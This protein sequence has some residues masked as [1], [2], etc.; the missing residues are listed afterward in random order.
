MAEDQI[1]GEIIG[2]AAS[3]GAGAMDVI[4]YLVLFLCLLGVGAVIWWV[5]S[6]K[7]KIVVRYLTRSGAFIIEDKARSVKRDGAVF[8]SF[9]KGRVV[10][11]PPPK[12]AINVTKKG[13]LFA[14]CY[15]TEDNPEPIW[16][17]DKGLNDRTL[18]E[19]SGF[20]PLTTQQRA[21]L[22]SRCVKAN[23]RK[24]KTLWDQIRDIAIPVTMLTMVMIPFIF[25]GDI[26]KTSTDA[27]DQAQAVQTQNAKISES[28][29][30]M[31]SVLAGKLEAG[32]IAIDQSAPPDAQESGGVN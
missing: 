2:G 12:T 24:G 20:R 32:E 23:S 28:N 19:Q 7:H 11:S 18:L 1:I 10:V 4:I 14:E 9:L 21:L 29:A 3:F 5:T 30:R 22:V 26:T 15:V 13:K 16:I 27:M 6:H 31:L 8:W 25:W 17:K